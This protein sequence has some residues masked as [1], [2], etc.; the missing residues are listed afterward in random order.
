MRRRSMRLARLVGIVGVSIATSRAS[1]AR[2]RDASRSDDAT[3]SYRAVTTC[4]DSVE[5]RAIACSNRSAHRVGDTL[6]VS[7]ANGR[8]LTLV[9]DPPDGEAP[10][11]YQYA[12]RLPDPPL[13]II[14]HVGGEASPSFEFISERSARS[15]TANDRPVFSPDGRRFVTAAE[16]DWNNCVE[17]DHPSL[18]VWR[19]DEELPALEW[20]L[21]PWDCRK[22]TG[23]GPTNPRWH[24][25]DTLEF[26]HNEEFVKDTAVGAPPVITRRTTRAVAVLGRGGWY[27]I[28]P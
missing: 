27:V 22:Q 25:G 16:P 20:R 6:F 4:W 26:T 14:E 5:A 9:D 8:T 19:F 24:S 11:G 2:A 3:V 1:T 13:Q 17:R 10:S 12:G 28:S 15:V 18:D 21:A 7:L 23:W